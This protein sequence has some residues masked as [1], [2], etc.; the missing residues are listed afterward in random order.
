MA[1]DGQ[2][3]IGNCT[4]WPGVIADPPT[5]ITV[6]TSVAKRL[7]GYKTAGKTY[8]GVLDD[9]MDAVPPRTFVEWA[10]KELERPATRYSAA[11]PKLGLR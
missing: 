4:N 8:A 7:K 1:H 3:A 2:T 5:T 6:P 10:L 9:L 11:R